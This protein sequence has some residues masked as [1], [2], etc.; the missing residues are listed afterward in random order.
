MEQEVKSLVNKL[1]SVFLKDNAVDFVE[2]VLE[3]K[4]EWDFGEFKEWVKG[5]DETKEGEYR[6]IL[7]RIRKEKIDLNILHSFL[8]KEYKDLGAKLAG[9][10]FTPPRLLSLWLKLFYTCNR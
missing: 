10:F 9:E 4:D 2:Y 1:K 3:H 7:E 5:Y 8:I 6:K